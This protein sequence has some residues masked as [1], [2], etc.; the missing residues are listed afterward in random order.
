MAQG[1]IKKGFFFYFG[2]FVLL[3][4]A[5]FCIC[6]VVMMF[7]PGSTVLWMQ[8]FTDNSTFQ[9]V[10]T[11]DDLKQDIDWKSV[12]NLE[13]S[14]NYANVIVERN[15]D[16]GL[17]KY[18]EEGYDRDGVYIVNNSKGFTT[19]AAAKHFSY[20]AYW[21][22][23]WLKIEIE[24]PTGF[25][26]F[27][28]DVKVVLHATTSQTA[29]NAANWNFDKMTIRVKTAD[30]SINVGGS[31]TDKAED[32]K[33]SALILETQSGNISLS[34]KCDTT[35]LK[36]FNLKTV[37]GTI[38]SARSVNYGEGQ[39]TGI[40]LSCDATIS[41]NGRGKLDCKAIFAPSNKVYLTCESGKWD[42]DYINATDIN[43][44][45][46]VDG[47]YLFN[48]VVGQ[49]FM[50]S[51]DSIS[52]PNLR[53]SN[54]EGNLVVD[55]NE[56]G[57][58]DIEV[59]EVT[60]SVTMTADRGNLKVKKAHGAVVVIS[61]GNLAVDVTM[62][63]D[64]HD[65]ISI[66]TASGN[67]NLNFLGTVSG[68]YLGTGL[69]TIPGVSIVTNSNV[70]INI[71]SAAK[72]IADMYLNDDEITP[73]KTRVEDD[74]ISINIG[75]EMLEGNT[76][77]PLKV[78]QSESGTNGAMEIITNGRIYFNLKTAQDLAA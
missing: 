63:Q 68:S 21:K 49:F 71:T 27:A 77:N 48:K 66:K 67:V 17:Q 1:G 3:L 11:T 26:Y 70:T 55:I 52:S 31:D 6:L 50:N 37:S 64:A 72:F 47:N 29:T 65:V 54:L 53:I 62:A 35:N 19:A 30:G 69:Q 9:V 2:L 57:H 74:K 18:G 28:K 36:T 24:E 78:N 56:E 45:N 73:T 22:D 20:K 40:A 42:I 39:N 44:V 59:G 34:S 12:T 51:P 58:P 23:S 14:C 10:K 16:G 75:Q 7:N 46:C 5:I 25:I 43:C 8:Y 76:K 60:G 41:I 61:N 33:P 13:I 4:I 38:S 15:S 32:I